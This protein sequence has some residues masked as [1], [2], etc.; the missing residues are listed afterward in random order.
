VV[1][2][3]VRAQFEAARQQENQLRERL[4]QSRA[5]VQVVQDRSVD[6]NLMRRE[7]ETNRQVYDSLLQRLKEVSVTG[8]LTT[9][10]IS[11][12]DEARAPLFP[13][14]PQPTRYAMIGMGLGLLLGL[15]LAFLRERWTTPSRAPTRS[16]TCTACRCWA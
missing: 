16:S 1:L 7:M 5:E 2:G 6:L 12:V 13:F 3:S 15:G 14:S 4:A 8:G 11:V 10:N 9:N